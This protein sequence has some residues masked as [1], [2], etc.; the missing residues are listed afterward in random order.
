MML[1]SF[2]TSH[3]QMIKV[4]R[5]D[6]KCHVIRKSLRL[7][8]VDQ[9]GTRIQIL[10]EPRDTFFIKLRLYAQL[11]NIRILGWWKLN[12]IVVTTVLQSIWKQKSS[13]QNHHLLSNFIFCPLENTTSG[14]SVSKTWE[15]CMTLTVCAQNMIMTPFQYLK[16]HWTQSLFHFICTKEKNS[17]SRN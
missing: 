1:K 3:L 14:R 11:I 12:S 16:L 13:Q 10:P 8:C 17:N 2:W 5:A 9:S 6:L 7:C 4:Q 15:I